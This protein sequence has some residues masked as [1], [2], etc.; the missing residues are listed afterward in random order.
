[1]KVE[2]TRQPSRSLPQCQFSGPRQQSVAHTNACWQRLRPG[3]VV[4]VIQKG[5]EDEGEMAFVALLECG[6]E[7]QADPARC[8]FVRQSR[9]VLLPLGQL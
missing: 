1:M 4:E 8:R 9:E 2:F 5:I 7:H 3:T 6:R